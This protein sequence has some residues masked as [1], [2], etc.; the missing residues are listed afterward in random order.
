M[1]DSW[2]T[3]GQ[4]H[5]KGS[6]NSRFGLLADAPFVSPAVHSMLGV[7]PDGSRQELGWFTYA[8]KQGVKRKPGH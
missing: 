2:R 8:P 7:L 5:E 3:N 6:L 1:N 4:W